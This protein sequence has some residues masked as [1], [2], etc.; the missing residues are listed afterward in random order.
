MAFGKSCI[1]HSHIT[2]QGVP[3]KVAIG[4]PKPQFLSET[5]E[6]FVVGRLFIADLVF[7]HI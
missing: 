3:K 4:P 1:F 7:F 6:I 2:I 5:F